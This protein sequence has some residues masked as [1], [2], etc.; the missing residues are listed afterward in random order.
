MAEMPRDTPPRPSPSRSPR[1]GGQ[2]QGCKY[3]AG[4]NVYVV[5]CNNGVWG[6]E[7]GKE[8]L[9][10]GGPLPKGETLVRFPGDEELFGVPK[11]AVWWI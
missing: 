3:K 5:F 8:A 9:A 11:A 2:G 10:V 7:H 4:K 1:Q 6:I